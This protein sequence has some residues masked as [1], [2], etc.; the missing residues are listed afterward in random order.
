MSSALIANARM[1]QPTAVTEDGRVV[2]EDVQGG[3]NFVGIGGM[4]LAARAA[5]GL[6]SDEGDGYPVSKVPTTSYY[7]HGM[8]AAPCFP[9]VKCIT[10]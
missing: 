9:V 7:R 2:V 10:M 8:E 5:W 3:I 1:P 6:L 4:G